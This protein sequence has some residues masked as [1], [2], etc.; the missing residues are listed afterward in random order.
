MAFGQADAALKSAIS[1]GYLGSGADDEART[2][3]IDGGWGVA[4]A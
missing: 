3:D 4:L 2:R 1:G